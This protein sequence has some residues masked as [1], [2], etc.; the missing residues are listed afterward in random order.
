M[1][2]LLRSWDSANEGYYTGNA[3]SSSPVLI[4]SRRVRW[5]PVL[6]ARFFSREVFRHGMSEI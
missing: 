2:P 1:T 6:M 3:Q 4:A 5:S